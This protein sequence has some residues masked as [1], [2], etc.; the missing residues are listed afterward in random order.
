M[1]LDEKKVAPSDH[2]EQDQDSGPLVFVISSPY[3]GNPVNLHLEYSIKELDN[4][5]H[6]VNNDG[7]LVL[8][9]LHKGRYTL[10]VRKQDSYA[11]Y[12][13]GTAQWIILP[14]WYETIWFRLL[15]SGAIIGKIG[16]AH[17]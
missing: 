17:V 4:N 3:Y 7:K 11:H 6:R 13:Y 8:T 15:V 16:R 9:G 12:S 5:W 14:Y 1:I 10:I 2:F